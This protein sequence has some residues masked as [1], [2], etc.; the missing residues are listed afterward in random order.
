MSAGVAPPFAHLTVASTF[1]LRDGAIAPEEVARAAAEAGMTHVALTDRDRLSGAVRFARAAREHGIVAVHGVDLALEDGTHGATPTASVRR[2]AP[3]VGE[4]HRDD[5]APRVTLLAATDEGFADLVRATSAAHAG[6]RG[7]PRLPASGLDAAAASGGVVVLLGPDSPVG[8]LLAQDLRDAA[9]SE[10]ARWRERFGTARV[11]LAVRQHGVAPGGRRAHGRPDPDEPGDDARIR[12]AL[13]LGARS[14][15]RVVA[16]NDVRYRSPEDVVVADVLRCVRKRVPLGARHVGRTTAAASF[17]DAVGMHA[18]FRERPDLLVGAAGLA[19]A[20]EADLGLDGTMT[21]RLSGLAPEA[22][23]TTLVARART[24][25]ALRGMGGPAEARL[26]TELDT[27]LGLGLADLFLAVADVV[28]EVRAAGILVACRGS[29]AGSL[30]CHVLGI[31]DVDP[32]AN[33]LL[34]ERF[35]NP[36]R[37]ELPDIDL[38]VESHRRE[39][40]YDLVLARFGTER[41]ACVAM[42]ETFQARSAVREVGHVLGLPAEELAHVARAFPHLRARDVRRA[43]ARLPELAH[44]RLDVD[45]LELL[46]DLVERLDGVPRHLAM[47]PC[48][49]VLGDDSLTARMPVE[50]SARG[51]PVLQFDKDDVAALGFVKLD[52][53]GVRMLSAL[54]HCIDLVNGVT[55]DPRLPREPTRAADP[56]LPGRD[57]AGRFALERIPDDDPATFALIRAA[58][59]VGMFQIE[60]P[61]QRE[62]LGRLQPTC[63]ADLV[64][65]ISLFRPGPVA[66]DMVTPYVARRH[67]E[68]PTPVVHPELDR[69]LAGT[70]GVIVHHEQVMGVIAALTGCDLALADLYRRRLADPTGQREVRDLVHVRAR[71]RGFERAVVERVW[72]ELAAFA[73]FG[74]CKAHAA[75]FAVPT[76][77]SAFCKTHLLPEFVAGLITHDPGMYPRRMLLDECRRAGVAVLPVDVDRSEPATTVEVVDAGLADHLLGLTPALDRERAGRDPTALLPPGWSWP[78]GATRP[79]P[80]SGRDAGIA[81]DVAPGRRRALR[82]GL[83]VVQDLA[84]REVEALLDARPFRSLADLRARGGLSIT[85]ALALV[86]AGGFDT[87]AGVGR[88]DGAADRRTLRLIAEGLWRAPRSRARVGV[89]GPSRIEQTALPI[90][91]ASP[92]PVL[93]TEGE[94]ARVRAELAVTGLDV[95]RHVVSFY[96]PLLDELG[97]V[98]AHALADAVTGARVRVAG[99]R[100]ALQSPPQRSGRRVLFLSLDDRTGSLQVTFFEGALED[101]AWVVRN[102]RLVVSEGRVARRGRRGATVVGERAWDLARLWRARREGWLDRA[103]TE[104]GTPRPHEHRAVAP[105]TTGLVASEWGRGSRG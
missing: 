50:R 43:L 79:L 86:E 82:L 87:L 2:P 85:A 72:R 31:S 19:A 78:Q 29:A 38:D 74:F 44:A 84:A 16:V 4:R 22:A 77:R 69:V 56:T 30:V 63:F 92:V 18:R 73:A 33:G 25:L 68:A 75:A 101:C 94:A 49:I 58:D 1:S 20:C 23:A 41:A 40:V 28:D 80:P 99:V 76:L 60:S 81:E 45:R 89:V 26:S 32:V 59:S 83:D 39:D 100:V 10:L 15:V 98:R 14:G 71:E 7:R 51:H 36:H 34:F 27:I 61:G 103:L 12:R 104:R 9:T 62:L 88:P 90:A 102:A 96:E 70:H 66:A 95:T 65:E 54:R 8:R 47:H 57:E 37:D 91:L 35:L 48:G 3:M 93:P 13:E 52:V 11:V 24:G 97:V 6:E 21:P 53:L 42:F 64:V 55:R 46:L 105:G 5:P 17:V 67:G